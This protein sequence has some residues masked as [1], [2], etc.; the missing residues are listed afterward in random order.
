MR[1]YAGCRRFV[2]NRALSGIPPVHEGEDVQ[3]AVF[4]R[5]LFVVDAT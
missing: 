3:E 2:W 1:Q 5:P 4:I